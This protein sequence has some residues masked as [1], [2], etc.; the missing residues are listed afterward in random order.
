MG[1]WD[2]KEVRKCLLFW[3]LVWVAYLTLYHVVS[4]PHV[5]ILLYFNLLI[6]H[7][8]V[9]GMPCVEFCDAMVRGGTVDDD[10]LVDVQDTTRLPCPV[11]NIFEG[12]FAKMSPRSRSRIDESLVLAKQDFLNLTNAFELDVQNYQTYGSNMMKKAGCSPDA[13]IQMAMQLASYRMFGEPLATY[14]ST[15]VRRFLHGRTET[16][17]TVSTASVDFC[18]AMTNTNHEK[19]PQLR[20]R[21]YKLLQEACQS[22]VNYVRNAAVA[23]G[24]DRHFMGLSMCVGQAEDKPDLFSHPLFVKSKHYRMSTSSLPNMAVGFG[25]VVED[26]FG[27]GYEAKPTSCIFNVTSRKERGWTGVMRE[28]LGKALDDMRGLYDVDNGPDDPQRT[29]ISRL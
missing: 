28:H 11:T 4:H 5:C 29:T 17:R 23:Q 1:S 19:D 14:E 12:A 16:T 24:V 10:S 6:E 3:Q 8:M 7:A 15:Q 21:R 20:A 22:H 25:P 9:D 18:Q 27:L 13:Y 2:F 26:G